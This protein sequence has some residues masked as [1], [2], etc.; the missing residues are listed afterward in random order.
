MRINVLT[1]IKIERSA[2]S[3]REYWIKL[4]Q[5][6]DGIT[7]INVGDRNSHSYVEPSLLI[8]RVTQAKN[9]IILSKSNSL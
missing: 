5:I 1:D 7:Q 3:A 6:C 8:K 4:A 9:F 2:V